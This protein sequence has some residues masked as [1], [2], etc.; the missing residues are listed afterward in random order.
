MQTDN[1]PASREDAIRH[2]NSRLPKQAVVTDLWREYS[3]TTNA[4]SLKARVV[5]CRPGATENIISYVYS[6][7]VDDFDDIDSWDDNEKSLDVLVEKIQELT[8]AD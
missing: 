3:T 7:F 2:I 4:P 1:T 6:P 5:W 8:G